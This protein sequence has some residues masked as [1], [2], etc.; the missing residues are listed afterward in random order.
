MFEAKVV[1]KIKTNILYLATSFRKSRLLRDDVE[2]KVRYGPATDNNVQM[3]WCMR[4]AC[5][6]TK[7][8]DAHIEYVIL[9][10]FPWQQ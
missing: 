7:A 6:I 4:F 8:T 10:D 1:K 2:N 5:W 9:I 3:I